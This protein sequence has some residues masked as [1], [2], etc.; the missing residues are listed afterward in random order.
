[1]VAVSFSTDFG[2]Q[3]QLLQSR[4]A[5]GDYDLAQVHAARLDEFDFLFS[6]TSP[7]V[8]RLTTSVVSLGFAGTG[9]NYTL[10]LSGN[11]IGPISTLGA[12]Q[13]AL[14]SGLATGA[15]TSLQ[16]DRTATGG[17]PKPIMTLTTS[18]TGYTL[19]S[20]PD[21][22]EI[23]GSLPASFEDLFTLADLLSN[24]D[25]ENLSLMTDAER[26]AYFN[27][28]SDFGITGISIGSD[29]ETFAAIRLTPTA[30]TVQ[31]GH[32]ELQITGTLPDDFGLMA[33]VAYDMF[34]QEVAGDPMDLSAISGL[35]LD[36][37]VMRIAGGAELM[38]VTGPLTDEWSTMIDSQTIGGVAWSPTAIVNVAEGDVTSGTLTH[39]LAN[40]GELYFGSNNAGVVDDIYGSASADHIL[41]QAGND[42]ISGDH[43][44]DLV[45]GGAG[46][47]HIWGE[48]GNDTLDG[49]SGLDI[50]YFG[51]SEYGSEDNR[52]DMNLTTAQ[53]TGEGLDVIRNFEGVNAGGGNDW[54]IGDGLSNWISG[55]WGD[56]RLIGNA[57]NDTLNGGFGRDHLR[58]GA[59][60]DT[61][62]GGTDDDRLYGE[63]GADRFESGTGAD[64]MY[65]G[66]D[67][68]RDVF[69]FTSTLDSSLYFGT[70]EIH[71]FR[72]GSDDISL[73][74]LDANTGA[75]GNQSFG[76]GGKTAAANA[77]WFKVA[78][79]NATV[80]ADNTGDGLAD[81]QLRVIGV[82]A[83]VQGDFLL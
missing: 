3:V 30:L 78:N 40:V 83:L 58:G 21:R 55:E 29:G 17:T 43:G 36:A 82:T 39:E 10:T 63:A 4:M 14:D 15:V 7:T 26:T 8:L 9:A 64:R 16:I 57:G 81:F 75:T 76:W 18:A 54:I 41:G 28:L 61:L 56:D 22:V 5:S 27:A 23:T 59:G 35:A 74:A 68:A 65:A 42:S 32:L 46:K 25:M 24:L 70:D 37:A 77:V 44:D 38:R 66:A 50:L 60:K 13:A 49:G 52:F 1:M 33:R 62:I 20:G 71:D 31:M 2:A 79:G 34:L 69:V 48:L 73:A 12:L 47:D 72:S 80:Y 11:G 53:S 45:N 67:T 51:S 6:N 19:T